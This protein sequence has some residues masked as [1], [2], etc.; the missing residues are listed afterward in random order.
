MTE[1]PNVVL[2]RRGYEAFQSGD[3]DA[4]SE[5][6]ADDA[7]WHEP[8]MSRIA[9]DYVGRDRVF[10]FFGKLSE[11]SG[12]TFKAEVVDLMADDER[13][14]AIQHSTARRDGKVLDARDVLVYEIR[15]GKVMDVQLFAGDAQEEDAFWA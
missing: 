1:H 9:G 10:E 4:L 11:L 6:F 7:V 5:L 12:G 3:V 8:G 15:D 13:A 14:I 2:A